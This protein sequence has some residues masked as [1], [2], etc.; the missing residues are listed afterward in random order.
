MP[1]MWSML[2]ALFVL[3]LWGMASF[4]SRGGIVFTAS[5]WIAYLAWLLWTL[6]GAAF[7]WTS[8]AEREYRAAGLGAL[9]FGGSALV[10]GGALAWLWFFA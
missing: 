5:R 7:T 4:L 3:A 6:L 8:L 1:V 9:L 10:A 2:S